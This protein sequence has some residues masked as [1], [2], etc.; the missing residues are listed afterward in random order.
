MTAHLSL[1]CYEILNSRFALEH[2]RY[3]RYH[4]RSWSTKPHGNIRGFGQNRARECTSR[5]TTRD[6]TCVRS[7]QSNSQSCVRSRTYGENEFSRLNIVILCRELDLNGM[8]GMSRDVF[9]NFSRLRSDGT[10]PSSKSR[11]SFICFKLGINLWSSPLWTDFLYSR[12]GDFQ[13]PIALLV[14][15]IEAALIHIRSHPSAKPY[16]MEPLAEA[17]LMFLCKLREQIKDNPICDLDY[18]VS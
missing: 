12:R 6:Q 18:G 4:V 15:L 2:N 8:V 7:S 9:E 3:R 14:R 16:L 10:R 17:V 1:K 11:L 5:V 13:S